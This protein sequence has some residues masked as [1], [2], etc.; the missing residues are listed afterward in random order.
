MMNRKKERRKLERGGGVVVN[1]VR[2]LRTPFAPKFR[3]TQTLNFS[4]YYATANNSQG[5][6]VGLFG[7]GCYQPL[8]ST[9]A[10]TNGNASY[11]MTATTGSTALDTVFPSGFALLAVTYREYKVLG[12]TIQVTCT[13]VS[14]ND[15]LLLSVWPISG[16]NATALGVSGTVGSIVPSAASG[17]AMPYA[18][19]K[20]CMA[21]NNIAQNTIKSTMTTALINGLTE[22]QVYDT[23]T[24]YVSVGS[25]PS[26]AAGTQDTELAWFWVF[27]LQQLS[28]VNFSAPCVVE[29]KVVY[30]IEFNLPQ[31]PIE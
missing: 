25:N 26:V 13:P 31:N 30:D 27:Q 28:N 15:P 18:K 7:N 6:L 14:G 12:S 9:T 1:P 11:K 19:T 22:R 20:Q 24:A 10:I 2:S 23:T 4:G 17:G 21:Y 3:T 29:C 5:Y 8:A 16:A